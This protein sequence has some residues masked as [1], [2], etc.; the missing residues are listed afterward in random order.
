MSIGKNFNTVRLNILKPLRSQ[1]RIIYRRHKKRQPNHIKKPI[2]PATDNGIVYC[3]CGNV[4]KY[5]GSHI[6]ETCFVTNQTR[7]PGNATRA[8]VYL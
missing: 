4:V 3:K 5:A 1:R 2:L 7:W 6:C 8:R